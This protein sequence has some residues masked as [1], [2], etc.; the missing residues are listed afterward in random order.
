MDECIASME[1]LFSAMLDMATLDANAP[2]M[3]AFA[4]QPLFM[5]LQQEYLPRALQKNISLQCADTRAV[6]HSDPILVERILRNLLS[7]AI[8]YTDHGGVLRGRGR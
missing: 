5:R 2:Q 4:L 3:R 6:V 8:A 7:N 1:N